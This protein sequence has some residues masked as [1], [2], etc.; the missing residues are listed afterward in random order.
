MPTIMVSDTAL[1]LLRLNITG[2]HVAVTAENRE[3]YRELAAA[4]LMYPVSTFAH[5]PESLF[6]FT[7]EGW[8]WRE[9]WLGGHVPSLLPRF[10]RWAAISP[11]IPARPATSWWTVRRMASPDRSDTAC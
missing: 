2:P 7:E 4:G 5:G 1:S 11:R 8:Q 10:I 3:A 9:E 6:R